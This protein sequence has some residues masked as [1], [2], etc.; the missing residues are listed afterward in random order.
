[1]FVDRKAEMKLAFSALSQ[2]K[3]TC[4]FCFLICNLQWLEM[5]SKTILLSW[6][7]LSYLMCFFFCFV[8]VVK[9]FGRLLSKW[10]YSLIYIFRK[11][12]MTCSMFNP[13]IERNGNAIAYLFEILNIFIPISIDWY[14]YNRVNV[15]CCRHLNSFHFIFFFLFRTAIV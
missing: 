9:P 8:F 15:P 2:R 1:M 4:E 14:N 13:D 10:K 11:G 7:E 5:H 6:F 12:S 3:I